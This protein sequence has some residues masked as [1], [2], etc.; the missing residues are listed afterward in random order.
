MLRRLLRTL[1]E[2]SRRPG[3]LDAA[4]IAVFAAAT[5]VLAAQSAPGARTTA[6]A[7]DPCSDTPCDLFTAADVWRPSVFD[8]PFE[9]PLRT[10]A[11]LTNR[12]SDRPVP[13]HLSLVADAPI[14][15]TR[16]PEPASAGLL[17]IGLVALGGAT[18][19]RRS[20]RRRSLSAAA[21]PQPR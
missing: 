17:A 11:R 4:S 13:R 5:R 8:T 16:V 6:V 1:R 20:V 10:A 21:R 18:M 14:E 19:H 15:A 9:R 2:A 12:A 3:G 7:L